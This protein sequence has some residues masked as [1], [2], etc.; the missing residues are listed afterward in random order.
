LGRRCAFVLLGL[1]LILGAGTAHAAITPFTGEIRFKILALPD[2]II[3]GHGDV[4]LNGT[5]GFGHLTQL[6]LAPG[7]FDVLQDGVLLPITDPAGAPIKGVQLNL[8]NG[9]G[10]FQGTGNS[11]SFGGVMPLDGVGKVCLFTTCATAVA[12]LTVPLNVVGSA[13]SAYAS[14]AVNLTVKGA[15]WTTGTVAIGTA[16]AMGGVLPVSNTASPGGDIQLVSPVFVSTNIGA[17]AVV[18]IFVAMDITI[19]EPGQLALMATSVA[20]L[21]ALGVARRRVR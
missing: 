1:V 18:P 21:V 17:S 9:V 13:G 5:G 6:D 10:A 2:V 20:A 3:P 12:N 4:T 19:P 11:G 7:A 15:P 8:A 16:S 14:A